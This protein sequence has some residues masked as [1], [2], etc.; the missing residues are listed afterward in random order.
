MVL[1]DLASFTF[2]KK[3]NNIDLHLVFQFSITLVSR[4]LYHKDYFSTHL[5]HSGKMFFCMSF[6]VHNQQGVVHQLVSLRGV[7]S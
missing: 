7:S 5:P 2:K 6:T 1:E 3:N 4:G